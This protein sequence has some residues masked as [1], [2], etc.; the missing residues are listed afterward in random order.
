LEF[1]TGTASG[2]KEFV[3]KIPVRKRV[4]RVM[5]DGATIQ[6]NAFDRTTGVVTVEL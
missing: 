5:T 1:Y 3:L 4:V 6:S 2:A